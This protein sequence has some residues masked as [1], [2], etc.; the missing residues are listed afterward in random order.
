MQTQLRAFRITARP[1]QSTRCCASAAACASLPATTSAPARP[2]RR[3][4]PLGPFDFGAVRASQP[5]AGLVYFHLLLTNLVER[6][7]ISY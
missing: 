4:E 7:A 3:L 5:H 2:R 1:A 6:V